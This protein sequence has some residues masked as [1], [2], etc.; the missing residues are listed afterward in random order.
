MLTSFP[1]CFFNLKG[2]QTVVE[3]SW[4]MK[5]KDHWLEENVVVAQVRFTLRAAKGLI[6]AF[7]CLWK[8]SYILK[9]QCLSVYL[10][11]TR[12]FATKAFSMFL[13]Q[14]HF[15]CF[16][17]MAKS[18][19]NLGNFPRCNFPRCNWFQRKKKSGTIWFFEAKDLVDQKRNI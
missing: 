8:S 6:N 15:L 12:C 10:S 4:T 14:K 19:L 16:N 5:L 18:A 17:T 1:K 9:Q 3:S 11:V 7:K 2:L 13:L